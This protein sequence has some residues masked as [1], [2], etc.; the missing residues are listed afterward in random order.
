MPSGNKQ[1]PWYN[2]AFYGHF[3]FKAPVTL[4]VMPPS[5]GDRDL[6][7]W[8]AIKSSTDP[9]DYEDFLKKFRKSSARTRSPRSPS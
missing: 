1:T 2:S 7:F 8:D 5:G 3:Y 9:A 6:A 4:N